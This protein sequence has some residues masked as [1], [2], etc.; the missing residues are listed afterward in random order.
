MSDNQ[1]VS[2]P[3][4]WL[5]RVALLQMPLDDLQD[6]AAE[7]LAEQHQGEPVA[8]RGINELG[9]IVTEWIDG[10]PPDR[11]VDLC[12]N[13]DS[14]AK[15]E[16]AYTHTDPAEV[17]RLRDENRRLHEAGEFL[18]GVNQGI[19]DTLRA[20][21]AERDALLRNLRPAISMVLNALDRDAAEG[22]AARGE[23]AAELRAAL[24]ASAE[25]S[26]PVKFEERGSGSLKFDKL[27]AE[28][29]A[30]LWA[31]GEGGEVDYDLA[32]I[33]TAKKLQALHRAALERKP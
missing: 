5:N 23:M 21:L 1:V 32:G 20:Q 10:S 2:V 31:S 18:D 12:G 3:R 11:M 19:E 17:E 28:Y 16:L 22:K 29:H 26:A 33:G 13:P 27:L 15:I 24:S 8:W 4:D 7:F 30:I 25:P 14:F 6:Q 9:E